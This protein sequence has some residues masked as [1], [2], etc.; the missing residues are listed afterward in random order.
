M[1]NSIVK[2]RSQSSH[3]TDA[4]TR[5]SSSRGNID[6][7][8]ALENV[9]DFLRQNGFGEPWQQAFRAANIHGEKFRA[10]GNYTGARELVQVPQET[11]GKTLF[12]LITLIRKVLNPDSDTPDSETSL[13][14]LR[15]TERPNADHEKQPL[16]RETA[17]ARPISSNI[18]LPSPDSPDLP[19]LPNSAQLL[20]RHNSEQFPPSNVVIGP[21]A[22]KLLPPPPPKNR[23][24]H[25]IKRPLSP[26]IGDVRQPP[27]FGQNQYLA[28]YNNRHSKNFSTD[29]NLSDQPAKQPARSSQDFQDILQRAAKD[30]TIAPQKRVDKKKSHEQISR[31]GI[32][33]RLFQRDRSKELVADFVFITFDRT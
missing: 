13:P 32:F 16:R 30:G 14:T 5:A 18:N 27:Q 31:P 25:D 11:H 2:E 12:K 15:Q 8:W 7:E 19:S 3:E 28:Q 10:C 24:P 20:P 22:P 6:D 29:S 21:P 33:S 4:I 23:P 17:P 9:I 26:N 1:H